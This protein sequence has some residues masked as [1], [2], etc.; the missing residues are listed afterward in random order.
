MPLFQ[1][2][3]RC[4]ACGLEIDRDLNAAINLK[5][6]GLAHLTGS[7]GSSP[8]SHACGDPSSGGTA[9]F[10]GNAVIVGC[11]VEP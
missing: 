3:F 11:I 5:K 2:V 9:L 6:Y 7:T 10:M 1:R 8:G 4:E